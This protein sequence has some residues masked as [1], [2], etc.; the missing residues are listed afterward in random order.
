MVSPKGYCKN[1]LKRSKNSSFWTKHDC[2][3]RTKRGF[4]WFLAMVVVSKETRSYLEPKTWLIKPA[5]VGLFRASWLCVSYDMSWKSFWE[6]HRDWS[7]RK[8]RGLDYVYFTSGPE[9]LFCLSF[10]SSWCHVASAELLIS[11]SCAWSL[12]PWI[13]LNFFQ[14]NSYSKKKNKFPFLFL[15]GWIKIL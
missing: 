2:F 8:R 4:D 11:G 13:F 12:K 9:S 10:V 15:F 5:T 6:G 7:L 14:L 3:E 1:T